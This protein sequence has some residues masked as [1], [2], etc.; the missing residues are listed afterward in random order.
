M[1][2]Y[3]IVAKLAAIQRKMR[4][5]DATRDEVMGAVCRYGT[6]REFWLP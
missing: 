6:T 3:K 4:S 5:N 2:H 1:G